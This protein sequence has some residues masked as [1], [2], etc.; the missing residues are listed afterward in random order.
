M[1]ESII[2]SVE[3]LNY[4]LNKRLRYINKT[5]DL[6]P[7]PLV[8]CHLDL[9][10]RNIKPM[11][12]GSICILDWGHSGFFPRFYEAAAAACYT[13]DDTYSTI[14]LQVITRM[15]GLTDEEK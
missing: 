15:M 3:D 2:R 7:Y 14:L 10:R 1:T 13:N 6:R 4:W 8:L 9:C 12:D 5:I 11:P